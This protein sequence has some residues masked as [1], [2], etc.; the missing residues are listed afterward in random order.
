MLFYQAAQIT[1]TALL[2]Y[3]RKL[4]QNMFNSQS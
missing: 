4:D 2:T 1:I 3:L